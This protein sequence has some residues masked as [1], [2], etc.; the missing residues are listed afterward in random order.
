MSVAEVIVKLKVAH[1]MTHCVLAY[2]CCLA[3]RTFWQNCDKSER[4]VLCSRAKTV[5]ISRSAV[6]V[7]VH[8]VSPW[9]IGVRCSFWQLFTALAASLFCS[10]RWTASVSAQ[11]TDVF[12]GMQPYTP[13]C[14]KTIALHHVACCP[15]HLSTCG[16]P[17]PT[18]IDTSPLILRMDYHLYSINKYRSRTSNRP[19]RYIKM[20]C[21]SHQWHDILPTKPY[22]QWALTIRRGSE[23]RLLTKDM[24]VAHRS[25]YK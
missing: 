11:E 9:V 23:M 18:R 17:A 21:T 2:I 20:R 10:K 6:S 7:G 1:F 25:N 5:S 24:A 12:R 4:R 8:S 16:R 13:R 14:S 3:A 19:A 22:R 15:C